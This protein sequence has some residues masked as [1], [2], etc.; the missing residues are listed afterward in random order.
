MPSGSNLFGTN[1][2]ITDDSHVISS[3]V[4]PHGYFGVLGPG[5]HSTWPK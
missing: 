1:L 2:S 3:E 5:L 4:H